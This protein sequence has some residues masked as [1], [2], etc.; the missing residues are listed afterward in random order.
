MTAEEYYP[1]YTKN[2]A[3]VFTFDPFHFAESYHTFVD[4]PYH[5]NNNFRI[6][7]KNYPNDGELGRKIRKLIKEL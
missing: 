4:D 6:M 5:F 1:I 3:E 2:K 7:E